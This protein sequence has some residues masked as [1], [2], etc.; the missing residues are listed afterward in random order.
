MVDMEAPALFEKT[1]GRPLHEQV[2]E[3]LRGQCLVARPDVA[4]PAL[5]QLSESLGVNHI[6]IS[7]ALRDLE[8][9]GLVRVVPGKGTFV[10]KVD[11]TRSIEM[12]TLCTRVGGLLETSLHTFQGMQERL[13]NGYSLYLTSLS[14]PP[15]P[16]SEVLLQKARERNTDALAIFDFEY[17]DYPDSF[18]ETQFI[19]ELAE[20]MPVVLV[21]KEHNLLKLDCIYCDPAPQ[22][23]T[24]LEECFQNGARK[25]GYIGINSNHHHLRHRL[26]AFQEF[27]LSHSLF[28]KKPAEALDSTIEIAQMLDSKPEVVVVS[29][30]WLAHQLVIE[31]QRQGLQLGTE[32]QVLCFAGSLQQVRAIMPYVSVVL[33]EEEEVGRCVINR[34]H[35]RLTGT[36]KPPPLTRRIPGKL[37][38]Q[39]AS[40]EIS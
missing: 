37:L 25:F 36:D 39:G 23:Q 29:D 5:R 30:P 21:G 14:M 7:R 40:S 31:A 38:R 16:T 32:V 13:Q 27:L 11:S 19:H 6:T 12:V 4:L 22:M 15:V 18:L 1:R 3:H 28:W 10:T 34:L 2:R 17:L 20:Q 35:N 8:A 26:A 33:L 9:E 24:F